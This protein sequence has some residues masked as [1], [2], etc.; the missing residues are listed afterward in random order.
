MNSKDTD[1]DYLNFNN[2]FLNQKKSHKVQHKSEIMA[3]INNYLIKKI[4]IT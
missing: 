4:Y 1:F 2:E 3:V